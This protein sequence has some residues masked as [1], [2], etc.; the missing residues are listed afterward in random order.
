VGT[1][2]GATGLG[3]VVGVPLQIVGSLLSVIGGAVSG[4]INET[5]QKD[6]AEEILRELGFD[7]AQAAALS[8]A[9]TEHLER[10]EELGMTPAQLQAL[11]GS[12]PEIFEN[13]DALGALGELAQTVGLQP[14]EL[15]GF[16]DAASRQENYVRIMGLT[17][18]DL[19]RVPGGEPTDTARIQG[20]NGLLGSLSTEAQEFVREHAPEA[21]GEDA[22]ARLEATRAFESAFGSLGFV[23]IAVA[24]RDE[25]P[26]FQAELM[27]L[28]KE[29]QNEN[30]N[31]L[32]EGITTVMANGG[33]ED[34]M[35]RALDA[36]RDAGVITANELDESLQALDDF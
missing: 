6:E 12:H 2:L 26:A 5:R 29:L 10:L 4:N 33:D 35:R 27:R 28:L 9:D 18:D 20:Y 23:E 25:R 17:F 7:D 15:E 13:N 19:R 14:D 31:P 24:F 32:S 16:L 3:A 34:S 36:A 1:I 8:N 21:S 11:A 22:E 30:D